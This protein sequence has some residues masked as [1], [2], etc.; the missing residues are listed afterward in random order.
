MAY[1]NFDMVGRLG[2]ALVIQGLGSSPAWEGLLEE[3][4]QTTPELAIQTQQDSYLPTD[5][6]S[7]YTKKIPILSAFT[8]AHSD[9]HKPS[10]RLDRLNLEGAAQ[11]GQ[12]FVSIVRLLSEATAAPPFRAQRRP[13]PGL[14]RSG[15]RVFLGTVPDYAQTDVVGVKL[16]GVAPQGPAETAGVR[17]GDL[18]IEVAGKTVENLYDYTFAL[19]ALRVGRPVRMVILREGVR[20]E[21]E[22]LPGSRD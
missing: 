19:Q 1:V 5:A 16:S 21:F 15:F 4:R 7:F 8:G 22:V 3:A 11:I 2:D 17:G 13:A 10:D 6:T 9:Y 14:G 18:I 12:L 20:L